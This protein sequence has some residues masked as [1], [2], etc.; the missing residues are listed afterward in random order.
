MG[1]PAG[2]VNR[3]TIQRKLV[4]EHRAN[5]IPLAKEVLERYMLEYV[6]AAEAYRPKK[7]PIPD[8]DE[9]QADARK[10]HQLVEKVAFFARALAPYQSPTYR[11]ITVQAPR[12]TAA[13]GTPA[14]DALESFVLTLAAVRRRE[15]DLKTVTEVETGSDDDTPTLVAVRRNGGE[16]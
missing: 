1:R 12:D 4:K 14:I 15:P 3:A 6:A 7:W 2:S 16:S 13:R 5:G 8:D 10:F 9:A 11:S